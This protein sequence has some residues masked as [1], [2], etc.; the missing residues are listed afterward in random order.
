M[1]KIKQ[2]EGLSAYE[3]I[4]QA[5]QQFTAARAADTADEIWQVEHEPVYTLGQAAKPEHILNAKQIPIVRC[6]RGG[7][8]T[9]HGPGQVVVYPLLQLSRYQMYAKEY[10][11][12]LED[13]IIATLAHFGITNACRKEKAPGVYVPMAGAAADDLAKIAA[14]GVK[15]SNGCTYHGL[16]INVAMDLDPFLGINPCGYEGLRTIDM[17]SL[18]VKA[19]VQAVSDKVVAELQHILVSKLKL[20]G[21]GAA[22]R[23]E[24]EEIEWTVS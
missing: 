7:Q 23:S 4:W 12:C 15:I 21:Q 3:P 19:T 9:Y 24:I 11:A 6:N 2:F 17:K 8:V 5:M 16:A 22:D 18:G 14:L 13:A 10:V 1:I 20:S